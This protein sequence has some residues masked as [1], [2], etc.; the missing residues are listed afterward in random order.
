MKQFILGCICCISFSSFGQNVIN[1][2]GSNVAAPVNK[3]NKLV[4]DHATIKCYYVFSKKKEGAT[5]PYRTDTMVLDIGAK[6]SRFYDPARLGRDSLLADRMK[7]MSNAAIKSVSVYKGDKARDLSSMPGTVGSSTVQGESYQ[8][9]KDRTAGKLTVI[10]YVAA[11]RDQFRYEDE[12]GI[13]P[14]KISEVTDTILSYTC[15][16]ATLNFRG[17]NY[18][19]WFAPD[20]PV[21]DGPWKF[22]GLPGLILK[23]EDD[24]QLFSF[25]LIGIQ[26]LNPAQPIPIDDAK[27][28]IKC[29]RAEFEKQKKKQGAGTQLNLNGGNVIIAE[30]PGKYEYIPMEIE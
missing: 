3:T 20:I 6:T 30:I 17:R 2:N 24:K 18:T 21:S 26:K 25:S 27:N 10:D 9:F 1:I 4:A 7:N 13:L 19:A 22:M 15:Q 12:L 14:W 11:G 16:K 8:I 28:N 5:G 29:T 23:V